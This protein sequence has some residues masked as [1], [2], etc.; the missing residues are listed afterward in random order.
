M[1]QQTTV[2]AV[3]PYYEKFLALWR[4]VAA[5]AAAPVDDVM[6]AWAGLGYYSRARNLHA[7]AKIVASELGGEFPNDEDAAFE[8]AG[9]RPLH[10]RRNRSDRI[11]PARHSH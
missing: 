6:K 4:D 10:R 2:P 11:R 9:N 7:C 1:L 3:K 8:A 5:L